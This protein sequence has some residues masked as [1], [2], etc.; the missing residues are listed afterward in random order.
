VLRFITAH[1]KK[2]PKHNILFKVSAR[3]ARAYR[4]TWPRTWVPVSRAEARKINTVVGKQRRPG[5]YLVGG[6]MP[7]AT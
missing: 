3:T 6:E 7:C 4:R 5:D 2:R 1:R